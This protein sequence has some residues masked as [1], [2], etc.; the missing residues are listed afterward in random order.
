[1]PGDLGSLLAGQLQGVDLGC[2]PLAPVFARPVVLR[3]EHGIAIDAAIGAADVGVACPVEAAATDEAGRGTEDR[4]GIDL[5]HHGQPATC[6][7]L[8]SAAQ[9]E[10]FWQP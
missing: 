3:Q 5:L 10:T 4:A 2:K 6:K 9:Y 1:M 7:A 8:R